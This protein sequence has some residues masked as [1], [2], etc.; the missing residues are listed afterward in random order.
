MVL[1]EGETDHEREY[2]YIKVRRPIARKALESQ[3]DS[4]AWEWHASGDC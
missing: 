3:D 2:S 4:D 1:D